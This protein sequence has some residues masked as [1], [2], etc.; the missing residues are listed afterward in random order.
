MS[1][2]NNVENKEDLIDE[3]E[4]NLIL[5]LN[6]FNPCKELESLKNE[7]EFSVV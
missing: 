6:I 4:L 2:D 3:L 1:K 5:V 7:Y